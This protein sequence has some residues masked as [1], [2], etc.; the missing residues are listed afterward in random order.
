MPHYLESHGGER[1][2]EAGDHGMAHVMF[3]IPF[4]DGAN[5]GANAGGSPVFGGN[6]LPEHA[7]EAAALPPI[8]VVLVGTTWSDGTPAVMAGM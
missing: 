8:S 5:W 4:K 6:Y 2:C 7:A 3:Y 1:G